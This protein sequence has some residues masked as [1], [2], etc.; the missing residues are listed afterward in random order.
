MRSFFSL[1][2]LG[3]VCAVPHGL[4]TTTTTS[5][6]SSYLTY[7]APFIQAAKKASPCVVSIK[8]Q[9]S[10][11]ARHERI[12]NRSQPGSPEEFWEHFFG[13]P[14]FSN[15]QKA[16]RRP[17][18]IF[19]SGFLVTSDGYILTNNH[20]VENGTKILVQLPDGTELTA[21]KIG[22]DAAT[23]IA[24][25]KVEGKDLPFLTLADSSKVEIG[26]WVMAI[27]NPLGLR[28]SV[29]SGVISAKGRSD[30]D[31]TLVEEFF[32]TDATINQGNSGGPLINLNGDVV[33]MNTAIATTTGGY[34]GICFAISSNLLRDVMKELIEHGKLNRGY[35]GIALQPL[36][37]DLAPALGLAKAQGALVSDVVK[38]GPADKAG[39]KSGDV[40]TQVNN[41][42]IE[43]AGGLKKSIA[44]MKPGQTVD[45]SLLRSGKVVKL[46]ATI[47]SFPEEKDIEDIQDTFGMI[48]EPV[49]Q[50]KAKQYNL[51]TATGLLVVQIDP[52]GQ[53]FS[54]GIRPG[55]VVISI[56]GIPVNTLEE[57]SSACSSI[58]KGKKVLL[59]LKVGH[60]TRYAS[61]TIE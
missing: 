52:A 46:Q 54:T 7:S 6:S 42:T 10:S 14:P 45:L 32:Q 40:I 50:E 37:S 59:Q 22:A 21:K 9:L 19:G 8:T 31:I 55:N 56:N 4:C 30:L 18:N 1:C 57:F 23:D 44:L 33:G 34:M 16:E 24:L 3:L 58:G 51:S 41:V 60:H 36:D 48:L 25:I 15:G 26:E 39:L 13:F 43:T 49:T 61:L 17:E 20:M 12:D 2:V 38:G 47:G 27:G 11:E 5:D 28:A 29:T 35:L 53:A